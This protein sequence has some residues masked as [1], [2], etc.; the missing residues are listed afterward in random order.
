MNKRGLLAVALIAM[1]AFSGAFLL[2]SDSDD[3]DAAISLNVPQLTAVKGEPFTSEQIL[4]P[5]QGYNFNL[6]YPTNY[7]WATI[8]TQNMGAGAHRVWVTGTTPST[9]GSYSVIGNVFGDVYI[10]AMTMIVVDHIDPEVPVFDASYDANGGSGTM[11]GH[12]SIPDGATITLKENSFTRM[13]YTFTGWKANNVGETLLPGAVIPVTED[14]VLHAQWTPTVYQVTFNSNGG[15]SVPSQAVYYGDR[16]TYPTVPTRGQYTFEGWYTD[17]ALMSLYSFTS[18]VT[19]NT[20]LYAKWS[21]GT[22]SVTFDVDGGSTVP[23]QVVNAGAQ[24]DRPISPIKANYTFG[25]WYTDSA[26]TNSYSFSAV[27]TS[28][29]TL[30]AKW[31]ADL[32]ATFVV[33]GGTAIPIQKVGYGG[34][35]TPP[36]NPTKDGYVFIGWYSDSAVTVQFSF[37]TA[38]V[39]NVTLYAKWVSETQ[40]VAEYPTAK[41]SV[42]GSGDTIAYSASGSI[43]ADYYQWDFG[44]Y[45]T[46]DSASGNH[47]YV[48]KGRTYV[49]TLTAYNGAGS[50]TVTTSYVVP[51][52]TSDDGDKGNG[53]EGEGL[54]FLLYVLI[55]I[56]IIVIIVIVSAYAYMRYS[57]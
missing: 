7:N 26:C 39:A 16:A 40:F 47:T 43:N 56:V 8:H 23:T 12:I 35:V 4:V 49:I 50:H 15:T 42:T 57:K 29:M 41:L 55:A 2:A 1:I 14:M 13:G 45:L 31:Y 10:L 51:A 36:T 46:S 22:Y 48:E 28:N 3:S 52:D 33:D 44:D 9:V 19:G 38:V 21:L 11:I 34:V 24:V 20:T 18:T 54:G 25:G 30:Y 37:S 6:T 27:V 53:D 17:S 32:T 5:S